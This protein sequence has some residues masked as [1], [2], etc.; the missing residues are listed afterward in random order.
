[1]NTP[2]PIAP[3]FLAPLGY[4]EMVC[5][6]DPL[7]EDTAFWERL[8]WIVGEGYGENGQRIFER[9]ALLIEPP[10]LT[11]PPV[12]LPSPTVQSAPSSA[13][14]PTRFTPPSGVTVTVVRSTGEREEGWTI[15]GLTSSGQVLLT[16][17]SPIGILSKLLS[18]DELLKENL[19]LL[20]EGL[21]VKVPRSS[22]ALDED[23]I[24]RGVQ[25]NRIIVEKPGVGRKQLTP[26]QFIPFNRS[27]WRDEPDPPPLDRK[28]RTFDLKRGTPIRLKRS[29]GA[30]DCTWRIEHHDADNQI[31]LARDTD[32]GTI[33]MTRSLEEVVLQNPQLVPIGLPVRVA[34]SNGVL[35][36]G[37]FIQEAQQEQ[38]VVERPGI[39]TKSL[40]IEELVA[41]NRDRLFGEGVGPSIMPS[42]EAIAQRW[43]YAQEGRLEGWI[44]DGFAEGGR[45]LTLD[46][47]GWPQDPLREILIVDRYS[48]EALRRHLARA[49]A[50]AER[51]ISERLIELVRFVHSLMGGA[52]APLEARMALASALHRGQK[53]LIGEV[54]QRL[55]G[56]IA[57]H[58]ALLFQ[59]LAEEAGLKSSLVRGLAGLTCPCAHAW[60]ELEGNAGNWLLIDLTLAPQEAV[61]ALPAVQHYYRPVTPR[62]GAIQ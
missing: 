7:E 50:W 42:R 52:I 47:N 61:I 3:L 13:L 58:R 18:I 11:Q 22:G 10:S 54:P 5:E 55:G 59:I 62:S 24:I 20:S 9:T 43:A 38:L 16:K 46:S 6:L 51:P 19:P 32:E 8:N 26:A 29:T 41:H 15:Q 39:G 4:A 1:M 31:Q 44:E 2:I 56:G 23:W 28:L 48:D 57:R 35:E 21:S 25:E 34:R 12:H 60:N 45:G 37:W 14:A 40:D 27:L 17:D 49:R 30:W 36:D 33:K 53:L